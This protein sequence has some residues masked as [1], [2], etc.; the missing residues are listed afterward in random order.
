M[1]DHKHLKLIHINPSF[2]SGLK[3][4][5][6]SDKDIK[7]FLLKSSLFEYYYTIDKNELQNKRLKNI[8]INFQKELF[9]L[10]QTELIG[11]ES[12]QFLSS[13]NSFIIYTSKFYFKCE[14]KT[15]ISEYQFTLKLYNQKCLIDYVNNINLQQW[16]LTDD[17]YYIIESLKNGGK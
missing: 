16:L 10:I 17:S 9:S 13:N 7:K 15:N 6:N 11:Q 14:Y 4:L 3:V 12:Y 5:I 2:I 1:K 8:F